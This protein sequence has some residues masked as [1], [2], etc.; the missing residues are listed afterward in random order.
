MTHTL[1]IFEKPDL[2]RQNGRTAWAWFADAANNF[3]KTTQNAE[4]I[5]ETV[6]LIPEI[7]SSLPTAQFLRSATDNSLIYRVYWSQE[8][9][10]GWIYS[11][12]P[13]RNKKQ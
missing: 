4:R 2:S 10:Q 11:L 6:F 7:Q 3:L 8:A 13:Y 5:D 9:D 1:I 12:D